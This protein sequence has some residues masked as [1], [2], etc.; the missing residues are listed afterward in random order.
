M[1][2]LKGIRNGL[3]ITLAIVLAGL[4][5]G[6]AAYGEKPK[7]RQTLRSVTGGAGGSE[8]S[9]D[10]WL[11]DLQC[12]EEHDSCFVRP[13]IKCGQLLYDPPVGPAFFVCG[14]CGGESATEANASYSTER[15]QAQATGYVT[16][17]GKEYAQT[18]TVRVNG[19]SHWLWIA[20]DGSEMIEMAQNDFQTPE[21]V[22]RLGGV[23][24]VGSCGE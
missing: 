7:D 18:C 16:L 13:W 1:N 23:L 8:P 2:L 15:E 9:C 3:L 20:D 19:L 10:R 12:T 24:P 14:T 6:W 22:E 4:L 11:L 21:T 17:G 5:G